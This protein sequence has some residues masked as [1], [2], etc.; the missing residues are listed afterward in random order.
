MATT[1]Q[2][3]I[4]NVETGNLLP[5]LDGLVGSTQPRYVLGDTT[6]VE[7]YLVKTSG[8]GTTPI[9]PVPFP[10]GS[11]VRLA[12]GVV[13]QHPTSGDWHLSFGGDETGEL[14]ADITAA[15]LATAINAL[16]SITAAGGVS[17]SKVGNQYQITFESY[18]DK[19]A[20]TGRS[21]SLYPASEIQVQTLQ[22]G[23]A[24][25]HEVVLVNLFVRPIALTTTFTDLDAPGGTYSAN[26]FELTGSIR[27]GSFRLRLSWG[28]DGTT[29]T[30]WT[31]PILPGQTP[32]QISQVVFNALVNAGWGQ[33]TGNA[34]KNA[35]GSTVTLLDNYKWRIDF[36]APEF[37]TAIAVVAPTV[38]DIDTS[39]LVP[40]EGKQGELSMATAEAIA[41]LGSESSKRAVLELEV[42][43]GTI[44][45]TLVQVQCDVVGEVIVDGAFAPVPL[46]VPLAESV[47][48]NRFVR[49]DADQT[50]DTSSKNQI[51]E[52]ITGQTTFTGVDLVAALVNSVAPS[53]SN[54]FVTLS[55]AAPAFDQSL[56]TTDAVNF[57]G[58]EVAGQVVAQ[59]LLIKTGATTFLTINAAGE[60]STSAA[61]TLG[62]I[63]TGGT[64]SIS[65][66]S[67][68]TVY[69][70]DLIQMQGTNTLAPADL[71]LTDGTSTLSANAATGITM[72]SGG[73]YF[74]DLS[75]QESAP[76]YSAATGI[77]GGTGAHINHDDYPDEVRITIGGVTYAMPA[78]I[79]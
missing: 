67:M 54:P 47:A 32:T 37:T 11:T 40:L 4:V 77:A 41:Y 33:V 9:T 34:T 6:P 43:A 39:D 73:I 44:T 10:A 64:L 15:D 29:Y 58:V 46:D 60:I 74:P 17:V 48:N 53:A 8:G 22:E 69:G 24:T 31:Q 5:T 2:R 14:D 38:I 65:G 19:G 16:P 68:D 36:V 52:N 56:N 30:T 61:A 55:E 1:A 50:L 66:G 75:Y 3:L 62:S 20:F 28:Q 71:I 72:N 35:W 42:T 76:V 25:T 18:G 57:T 49:R 26:G 59:D 51:W 27:Q 79:V 23:D 12:V 78:R 70:H 63:S 13:N 45:Q 21:S 7:L